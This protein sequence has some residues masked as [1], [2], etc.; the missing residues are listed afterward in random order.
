MS[1][2]QERLSWLWIGLLALLGMALIP[3]SQWAFGINYD[4]TLRNVALG[5]ALLGAV[6]G[7]IGCFA[8]LRRESLVGDT[9]SHAALPGVAIAFLLAGRQMSLL[10]LGAAASSWLGIQ[11]VQGLVRTTRLKRE[12]AMAIVLA[13]WFAFGLALLSYIQNRADA[14]QAGLKSF[15][16]GQA[17]AIIESDVQLIGLVGSALVALVVL[18]WKEFKLITF[19]I[20]FARADGHPV[21]ALSVLLSTL[22]VIVI[23][24]GLQLAGVV[25]VVG[26]LIAPASAARQWTQRLE[27]MVILAAVFGALSGGSGA[28]ISALDADIPTGPMII[29]AAFTI[30]LISLVFAPQRGILWARRRVAPSQDA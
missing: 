17:A 10:L 14:G 27:K 12:A 1:Q 19:D 18:F 4:Y 5:G 8:V 24:L 23:I 30:V 13:A 11:L 26:L 20:E 25:L 28:V 22:I 16:F 7:F 21:N 6:T 2:A 29:V 15:I 9:V 3:F